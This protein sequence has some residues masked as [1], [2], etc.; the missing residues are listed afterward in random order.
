MHI[1]Y[2]V[3]FA[4]AVLT[5]IQGTSATANLLVSSVVTADENDIVPDRHLRAT[6]EDDIVP[7]RR[8]GA[9]EE[10]DGNEEERGI[11]TSGLENLAKTTAKKTQ[12]QW[13][14]TR[15]KSAEASFK[16]LNL[17]SKNKKFLF[18]SKE[19]LAWA[20]Y[21]TKL[22]KDGAGAAMANTLLKHFDNNDEVLARMIDGAKA[23]TAPRMKKLATEL[24]EAQFTRWMVAGK[25]PTA[26][27]ADLKASGNGM[28][29]KKDAEIVY[30]YKYFIGVI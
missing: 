9:T 7:D 28:W 13:W 17:Q 15:K 19:F 26:V 20:D 23:S 16:L 22:K 5:T 25:R 4:V 8:L 12:Q 14:L 2:I 21:V 29:S 6:N 27:K 10:D 1:H 11:A 24:Q 3:L 30:A 18:G